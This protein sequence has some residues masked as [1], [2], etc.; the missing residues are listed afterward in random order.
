MTVLMKWLAQM[1]VVLVLLVSGCASKTT[2]PE[3][4]LKENIRVLRDVI[5]KTVKN[6]ERQK[7]LLASI[8]SLEST[9]SAYN[10]TYTNFAIE[11]SKLNRRYDTPREKLEDIQASLRKHR[12]TTLNK[13]LAI[14]FEMVAQT[15][16][17]EWK[18]IAEEEWQRVVQ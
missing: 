1:L 8:Q 2:D 17:E 18:R 7:N 9:L 10:Q 3:E 12:K 15:S 13:L 14:H 4:A 16:E 6:E 5:T 11:F